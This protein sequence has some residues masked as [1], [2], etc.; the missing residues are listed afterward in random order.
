[1]TNY[2]MTKYRM[3][4]YKVGNCF[5]M[6]KLGGGFVSNCNNNNNNNIP[7]CIESMSDENLFLID[8]DKINKEYISADYVLDMNNGNI[9]TKNIILKNMSK[10]KYENLVKIEKILDDVKNTKINMD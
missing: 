2:R 1:M 8:F 10:K 5:F 6:K 4:N 3:T 9:T 7:V